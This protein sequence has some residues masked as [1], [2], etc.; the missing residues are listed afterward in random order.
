[1]L[2]LGIFRHKHKW[3]IRGVNRWGITTYRVCL[4]CG[5]AQE[6]V[7]LSFEEKDRFAN[8]D[9]IPELDNQFDDK[10]KFIFD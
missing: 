6:R 1:M 5:Q 2:T 3:Q 7:N 10:G 4:K 9:R 8:C